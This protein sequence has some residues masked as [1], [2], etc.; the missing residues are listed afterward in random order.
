MDTAETETNPLLADWDTPFELPPF[1]AIEPAH[2]RPA[3]EAAMA[4]QRADWEAIA[5]DPAPPSFANT[6]AALERSGARL[7]RVASVFFTLAGSHTNP[8]IQAIEREIGPKLAAHGSALAMD[9]RIWARVKA[10]IAAGGLDAEAA[11]VTEIHRRGFVRGGA[12]LD[13]A[14]QARLREILGRLATL[15]TG[16]SQAVLRE[17]AEWALWLDEAAGDL[18]GLPDAVV[19]A[20]AEAAQARGRTGHAITLSRS[21]VEPFLTHSARRD[22]REIAWRAWT[23]RGEATNWP[24][25]EETVALRREMAALLGHESYAAM[26]LEH[27]MAK[28]PAAVRDLLMRVWRPARA[29]AEAERAAL[30]ALAAEEGANMPLEPWDW[31]RLEDRLRRRERE[32]D[33]AEVT[34]HLPLEGVIAAAFDVAGRLFGLAFRPVE[35]L[36]L[37]HPDARAWEVSKDGRHLGLFVGDYFARPSKRSGAWC[38]TL[39]GQQALQAPERP[40]VLNTMNFARGE[41]TLLSMDDARTLFH[42]FGHALHNLMS[43]VTYPSIAG[44]RVA[45]DF[46]ELPSQLYEHWLTAPGVLDGH[47]RHWRTGEPM[48]EALIARV[49][50][51]ETHGQGR[52]TVEYLASAL[53]DLAMHEL[54]DTD[55][56]DGPAFEAR[57]LAE[58]G[59]PREIAMRHRSPH[60]LHVFAGSGY[61]A[62]YYSYLW[63]EVMDADAFRAFEE[64][65][66]P[67]D[68]G[69]AARL[70]EHVLTAG[71]RQEPDAAYVAFRGRM[72]GPEALLEG[73]GLA[74]PA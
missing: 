6:V 37:H 53:V 51:A 11:R 59:L 16:F 45:R 12:D 32:L 7:D 20:A 4:E 68:P 22:L 43:D 15:G 29:K 63:S 23:G 17:E 9:A 73:R 5:T 58:I 44:T 28:T 30:E 60:F 61:A 38:S 64:T 65:G 31:R 67:F 62:G 69:L 2:F 18:A 56:F 10:V 47:A 34:A 1:A 66:D 21:S 70:A 41:P 49:K 54:T 39:R 72:P 57:V 50:A 42:E 74:E 71:A 27:Q 14:G 46:V 40:I 35:G 33:D 3:F 26:R 13:A 55:G 48:P 8:E 52:P 24:A 19:A 36:A 25:I